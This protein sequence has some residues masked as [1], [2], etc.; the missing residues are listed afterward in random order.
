MSQQI[1]ARKQINIG[2]RGGE[3]LG[4]VRELGVLEVPVDVDRV[5]VVDEEVLGTFCTIVDLCRWTSLHPILKQSGNVLGARRIGLEV[6][7]VVVEVGG[8]GGVGGGVELAGG[9]EIET[10]VVF[11]IVTQLT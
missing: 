2:R 7:F 5:G 3:G 11:C 1:L 9:D 6:V 10:E 4:V 8:E